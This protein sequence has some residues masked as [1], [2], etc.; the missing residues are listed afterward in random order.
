MLPHGIGSLE[1]E[2]AHEQNSVDLEFQSQQARDPRSQVRHACAHGTNTQ[3]VATSA[4]PELSID[5]HGTSTII[6][7]NSVDR[8]VRHCC[9]HVY[10]API[11]LEVDTAGAVPRVP[12]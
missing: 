9:S 5:K 2:H 4:R 6:L 12:V 10:V 3:R 11:K 1:E 7:F 8:R